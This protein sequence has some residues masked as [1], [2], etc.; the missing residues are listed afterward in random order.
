M[1]ALCFADL[2]KFKPVNDQLGHAAGDDLLIETA[3][4]LRVS[5]RASDT[6]AR[7]GGDEFGAIL[8]EVGSRAEVEEVAARIVAELARP[9]ELKA[10][11]ASISCSIG[12]ALFPEHGVDVDTLQHNA[13]AA[14]YAV[15]EAGRNAYR[16]YV[17]GGAEN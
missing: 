2:D 11:T 7:L 3:R 9:F 13:D 8:T 17:I 12:V 14:L 5:V 4:R 1:F 15:K 16:F 6:V 10:G